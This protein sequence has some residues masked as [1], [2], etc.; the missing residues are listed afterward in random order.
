MYIF[1]NVP[2]RMVGLRKL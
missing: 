1:N 2:T